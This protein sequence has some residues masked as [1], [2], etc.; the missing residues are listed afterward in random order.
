LNLH[1]FAKSMRIAIQNPFAGQLVAETELSRR[2]FLAAINLG[3]EV[4]EA[5]TALEI[6]TFQPDFVIA[7]HNNS[8]KLSECPTYGCMW[9][10]PS[11]FEG[12]EQYV[13]NV[14]SYDGYLTSSQA[15][16]RWLHHLLYNTPKVF[17][18][19]PFYTSCPQNQYQ[20]PQLENLRLVYLGSNWDGLRFQQLFE[21]LEFEGLD[22]QNYLAVYGNPDG[23]KHL[24]HAYKGAIPYDGK[25]VL[26]TLN[27]AGVG[28]C[29]HREEHR[30]A[31]LPS[32]RIFEI[33][34]S[35]AIAI[36]G[37][38]PFIR[39]AF[40]DSVLYL[41]P[42]ANYTTQIEQISSLMQW[43][44]DNPDA[45][46]ARSAK[47]HR[48]F[49]ET[50]ALEKLLLNLLP[51]HQTLVEQKGFVSPEASLPRQEFPAVQIIL[52]YEDQ[53]F[54]GLIDSLHQLSRQTYSNCSVT[55]VKSAAENAEKID[56]LLNQSAEKLPIHV[57]EMANSS[58]SSSSLWAGLQAIASTPCDYFMLLDPDCSIYPNHIQTLVSLL[59]QSPSKAAYSGALS[60]SGNEELI[61][62]YPYNLE[63]ILAFERRIDLSGLMMKRS[64]L[65]NTFLTDPHLNEFEDLCVLLQV[66]QRTRLLFSYELTYAT[67][68][69]K[70]DCSLSEMQDGSSELSRLKFIFWHQEFA[71]GKTLQSVQQAW[72]AQQ[73]LKAKIGEMRSP[74]IPDQP[75]QRKL[76]EAEATIAAMQ[77]SKFWQMRSAW[78]KLKRFL[79]LPTQAE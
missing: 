77:T 51:H 21:K 36:C 13:K 43:I 78:F 20:P 46:L 39:E 38:H 76:L 8:P 62:F 26:Q 49:L 23:W 53:Q 4:L 52:Q 32:M 70:S 68:G 61:N 44:K 69:F 22:D 67:L 1:P 18:T 79:G 5:L 71:P 50:Y 73:Q 65:D 25:S 58:D 10:P 40:G 28:L 45:A 59:E 15:I 48:I 16:D 14:L 7:L 72:Q 75:L 17:F 37:D 35:G 3:W 27:Q 55:L 24:N 47:A 54:D 74:L 63:Q 2:I 19:A 34:A 9:N 60:S 64:L 31:A 66:M 56:K 11:F 41:D 29:L 57:V 42:D 33:V 30:Q 12:T 6:K